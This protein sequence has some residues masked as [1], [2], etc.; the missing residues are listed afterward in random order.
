MPDEHCQN[1]CHHHETTT[2]KIDKIELMLYGDGDK[3]GL[4]VKLGKLIESFQTVRLVVYSCIGIILTSFV[5]AMIALV[6]RSAP[7]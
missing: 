7:K 1:T 2:S 3:D 6:L 4:L 5:G